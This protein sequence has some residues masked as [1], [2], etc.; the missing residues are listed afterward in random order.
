M[1]ILECPSPN[2]DD[3][4]GAPVDLLILHYTGMTDPAAALA[5]LT[6][7]AAKVAAHY[8]VDEDGAVRRLVDESRRAWHAGV[9][10]WDGVDDVNAHS[11]GIEIQNPGHE[12]GYRPFPAPQIDAV[13]ALCREVLA[14]HP[15]P[16]HRV[17]GHSD[18]APTRKCD[19]G[20]LFPWAELAAAGVGLWP[21]FTAAIA[22]TPPA[23][24]L[25]TLQRRLAGIGY[26]I[27]ADGRDTPDSRAVITAFQRHFRP[28]RLDGLADGETV[29]RAGIVLMRKE[30]DLLR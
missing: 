25:P 16:P 10:H 5:R 7:P 14:R 20:E 22:P 19:P 11:I 4:R 23:E 3:R 29:D 18:V 9:A 28:A 27:A 15:I 21:D 24:R 12:F 2:H 13:I 8:L 1:Q 26:R 6:D 17:L 30:Q